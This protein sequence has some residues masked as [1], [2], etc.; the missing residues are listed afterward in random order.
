MD[1]IHDTDI[2]YLKSQFAIAS[3]VVS[4]TTYAV[5]IGHMLFVERK[6]VR[7]YMKTHLDSDALKVNLKRWK[8]NPQTVREFGEASVF[9]R[10]WTSGNGKDSVK[11]G[12]RMG[13]LRHPEDRRKERATTDE[14]IAEQRSIL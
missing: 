6:K 3:A 10:G 4:L 5:A 9:T 12:G 8:T 7:S 1:L 11:N 2:S 13:D 14:E